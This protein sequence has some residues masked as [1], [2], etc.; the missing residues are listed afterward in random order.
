M[1]PNEEIGQRIRARR[2][3]LDLTLQDVADKV[4]VQNSTILRYEKGAIK[5]IKLPV[6]EAIASAL[7]VNPDWLMGETD[8]PIDYDDPDIIASIPLSYME[9]FDGNV[10]AAYR[11]QQNVY[12][13]NLNSDAPESRNERNYTRILVSPSENDHLQKYRRLP[14]TG[15]QAVENMM[16]AM[17]A[18][19]SSQT[20]ETE[21]VVP[22]P[23]QQPPIAAEK[24]RKKG[25][26]SSDEETPNRD[27]KSPEI[28]P[29]D[30]PEDEILHVAE[31]SAADISKTLKM[32]RKR[33]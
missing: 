13:E 11:Y 10:E 21:K 15:K 22:R 8:D 24:S 3:E 27:E 31:P 26:L 6:I 23:E 5:K 9:L 25:E 12:A 28:N 19:Q 2:K 16:D 4:G 20:E 33:D 30:F 1:L 14:G 18:A 32:F 29:E 17:L 7:H